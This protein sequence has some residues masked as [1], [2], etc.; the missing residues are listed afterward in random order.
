MVHATY[1]N[2]TLEVTYPSIEELRAAPELTAYLKWIR[3]QP[4]TRRMRN[5]QRR[6]KI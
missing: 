2:K 4:P 5:K 6:K 3:M 1:T